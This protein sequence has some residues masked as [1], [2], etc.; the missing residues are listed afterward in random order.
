MK[1]QGF[2]LFTSMA[3]APAPPPPPSPYTALKK[4]SLLDSDDA[5][6]QFFPAVAEMLCAANASPATTAAALSERFNVD[7][8]GR[9][10]PAAALLHASKVL[11]CR[12]ASR[13][14]E[15]EGSSAALSAD[16]AA[17]GLGAAAATW[18]VQSA[19]AACL[20]IA[21]EL[22]VAQAHATSAI[23][24]DYLQ[25]FDWQLNYVLGSSS[26]SRVQQPLVAVQLAIAKAGSSGG[27]VRQEALELTPGDL[28]A[29]LAA[30]AAA[31][32][33][34]RSLPQPEKRK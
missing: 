20:P 24:N 1:R 30:L 12:I 8:S 23:S 7:F 3:L 25:D 10:E 26:I 15:A 13:A 21:E 22:R 33:V 19:E 27:E 9:H 2:L 17:A 31:N 29:T 18:I 11:L 6:A 34:M 16:L 5:R 14:H 32:Q 4:L 28:D